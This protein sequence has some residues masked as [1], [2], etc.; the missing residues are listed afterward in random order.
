LSEILSE[1]LKGELWNGLS[2]VSVAAGV[3]VATLI[4]AL[5]WF[6]GWLQKRRRTTAMLAAVRDTTFGRY[7]ARSRTG[8]WGFAVTIEPPPERFREFNISYQPVSIFDPVDFVRLWLGGRRARFQISGVFQD[9]PT[10]EIIWVRGQPPA[11][12]LGVNPGRAPWVHTRLD[13]ARSEYATRGANVGAVKR[14]LQDM[15]ARFTPALVWVSVQREQRPQMRMVAEG[16]IGVRDVS[17]LIA[18]AR[19]LGRAAMME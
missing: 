14:V 7:V 11:R 9:A 16:R 3:L 1:I 17:P 6:A 4:F 2:E 10:A 15:Y 13:F 12:A 5:A 19:A 18:S 8:A